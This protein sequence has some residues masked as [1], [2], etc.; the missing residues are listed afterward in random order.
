[1]F[2][3]NIVPAAKFYPLALL[4]FRIHSSGWNAETEN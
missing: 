1:M 2:Q 4:N 3:H